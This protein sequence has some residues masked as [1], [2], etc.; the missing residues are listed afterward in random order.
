MDRD[1]E[2]RINELDKKEKKYLDYINNHITNVKKVWD[3]ARIFS[4]GSPDDTRNYRHSRQK[5]SFS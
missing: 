5:Y 1:R 2:I 4:S 3:N